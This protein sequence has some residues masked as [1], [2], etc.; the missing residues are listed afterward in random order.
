MTTDPSPSPSSVTP[1]VDVFTSQLLAPAP[2][3]VAAPARQAVRDRLLSA[4]PPLVDQLPTGEQVVITLPVLRQA[5]LGLDGTIGTDQPFAWKP[6]F[7]RRSLGLAAIDAC[8]QH[9]YGTPAEAVA[10][11]ADEAVATW[12]QTGWRTFHWEPWFGGLAVGARS[13]VLAEAATWATALWSAVD[14]NQFVPVPTVGGPDDQW[15]CTA[16]RTVRLKAR[17]ELRIGVPGPACCRNG[18][19]GADPVGADTGPPVA[20]VSVSSGVPSEEWPSELGFL[21]LVASLRSPSRPVPARVAGLWPDSGDQRMIDVDAEVLQQA[22]DRVVDTVVQ[23]AAARRNSVSSPTHQR[24]PGAAPPG[25]SAP[26][27]SGP[28]PSS[29]DLMP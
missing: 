22:A 16:A 15:I 5:R 17:S 28:G 11:V 9:R 6:A 19:D 4:V 13:A 14:W 18:H 2:T 3:C 10:A 24:G 7:A 23:W 20:L 12:M 26:G 27:S 21:A 8:L 25:G 1:S 29:T